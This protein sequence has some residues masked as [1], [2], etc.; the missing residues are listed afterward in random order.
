MIHAGHN[1]NLNIAETPFAKEQR[2]RAYLTMHNAISWAFRIKG[3]RSWPILEI[4]DEQSA[5]S[6]N[7]RTQLGI[8]SPDCGERNGLQQFGSLKA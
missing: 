6:A 7:K 1:Q 3:R 4:A 8:S 2:T 5:Q